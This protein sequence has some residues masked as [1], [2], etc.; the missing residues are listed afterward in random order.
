MFRRKHP[1]RFAQLEVGSSSDSKAGCPIACPELVEGSPAL[2]DM[3][4]E[5][6]QAWETT[7]RITQNRE[8]SKIELAQSP[9]TRGAETLV[10]GFGPLPEA[11]QEC[12]VDLARGSG[13]A[14]GNRKVALHSKEAGAAHW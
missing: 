13:I 10:R 4:Y 9:L 14:N 7:S 11:G 5:S 12:A 1:L 8:H 3:G 6:S 2:G